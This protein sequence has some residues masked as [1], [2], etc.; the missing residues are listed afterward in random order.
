[1]QRAC[2]LLL[3]CAG[4]L[5]TDTCNDR[6][7]ASVTFGDIP[8]TEG[9]VSHLLCGDGELV[10]RI[11]GRTRNLQ[12]RINDCSYARHRFAIRKYYPVTKMEHVSTS[13]ARSEL[14][15][16]QRQEN[17]ILRVQKHHIQNSAKI[18][19]RMEPSFAE[20]TAEY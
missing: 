10:A 8:R 12:Q 20:I 5:T 7:S 18:M 2:Q 13:R 14:L 6:E 9:T 15:R 3:I 16:I 1:M 17:V 19:A 11:H 4:I